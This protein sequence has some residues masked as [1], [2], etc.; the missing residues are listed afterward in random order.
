MGSNVYVVD[1]LG[2]VVAETATPAIT[3]NYPGR[4]GSGADPA[5]V[6]HQALRNLGK[7]PSPMP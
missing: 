7:I 1:L 2:F 5:D 4:Q 6:A 3:R